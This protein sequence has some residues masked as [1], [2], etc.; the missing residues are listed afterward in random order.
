LLSALQQGVPA[1][2]LEPHDGDITIPV[3]HSSM[4]YSFLSNLPS[5]GNVAYNSSGAFWHH[6]AVLQ[7]EPMP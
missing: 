4:G 1:M 6:D 2:L 5:T 3:V 7:C